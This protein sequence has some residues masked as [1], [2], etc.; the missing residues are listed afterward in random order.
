MG[1]ITV[2][3]QMPTRASFRASRPSWQLGAEQEEQH[4]W[5]AAVKNW[6]SCAERLLSKDAIY[7]RRPV[8]DFWLG[9]GHTCEDATWY[10]CELSGPLTVERLE[11]QTRRVLDMVLIAY[12]LTL[13]PARAE[14]WPS[15]GHPLYTRLN[16]V[17]HPFSP[18]RLYISHHEK[19]IPL[20]TCCSIARIFGRKGQSSL[21]SLTALVDTGEH[22]WRQSLM[23][24]LNC[25]GQEII[26]VKDP[27]REDD[28]PTNFPAMGNVLA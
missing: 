18:L 11:L 16:M 6:M 17:H 8:M 12:H 26:S 21:Q 27:C 10:L 19:K 7:Y 14:K 24:F 28:L 22:V 4:K 15:S 20:H 1:Q 2:P 5:S 13:P 23:A 3:I 25:R 9:R